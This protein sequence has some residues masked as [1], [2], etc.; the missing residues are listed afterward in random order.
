[1]TS[2]PILA[3]II[4]EWSKVITMKTATPSHAISMSK[5]MSCIQSLDLAFHSLTKHFK[6]SDQASLEYP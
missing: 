5:S 1:M 4:R 6:P 2:N 3:A